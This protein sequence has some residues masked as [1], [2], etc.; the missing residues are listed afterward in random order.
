MVHT[1]LYASESK[2]V[3]DESVS[4][5][6]CRSVWQRTQR[7]PCRPAVVTKPIHC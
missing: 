2:S 3:V 4:Q 6:G 1:A 5:C 7:G